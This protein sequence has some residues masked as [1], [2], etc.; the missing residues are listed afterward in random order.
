MVVPRR[1]LHIAGVAFTAFSVEHSLRAPAV[2][3][4]ITAGK[5]A[6]FY[7]PDLVFIRGRRNVLDGVAAYIGDGSTV[8]C[9]LVRKRGRRLIGRAPVETQIAWC[10]ASGVPQVLITHCGTQIVTAATRA[11]EEQLSTWSRQYK[12]CVEVVEDGLELTL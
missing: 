6:I 9:N 10:Q 11:L 7:A 4:R 3:Y 2:G 1:E 12:L 5:T 8:S